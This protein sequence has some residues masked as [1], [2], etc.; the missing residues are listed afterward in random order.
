M[1]SLPLRRLTGLTAAVL[2]LGACTR[3]NVDFDGPT[4]ST[5]TE[6]HFRDEPLAAD[7][8]RVLANMLGL[9]GNDY[10]SAQDVLAEV[11]GADNG[12]TLVQ[13]GKLC[14]TTAA[15]APS[16]APGV[17]PVTASIYQL[18]GIVRRAPSLQLTADARAATPVAQGVPA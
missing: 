4:A 2:L 17:A 7:G 10:E 3:P 9:P 11:R 13:G 18:D 14:N 6:L 5:L 16:Q 15:V 1:P 8:L 12:Q